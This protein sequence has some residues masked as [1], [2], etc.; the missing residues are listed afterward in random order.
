MK[1]DLHTISQQL[2]QFKLVH[3]CMRHEKIARESGSLTPLLDPIAKHGYQRL[4]FCSSTIRANRLAC[5]H[6]LS[7]HRFAELL[8]KLVPEICTYEQVEG[9]KNLLNQLDLKII[10][11]DW[12][13]SDAELAH[14]KQSSAVSQ[15]NDT[16][17]VASLEVLEM[18]IEQLNREHSSYVDQLSRL[19]QQ[20]LDVLQSKIASA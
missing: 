6:T 2:A 10:D 9:W 4:R 14:A 3:C 18:Q 16:S 12:R 17:A 8:D 13:K 7:R 15:N 11:V 19:R 1:R 20:V 5:A